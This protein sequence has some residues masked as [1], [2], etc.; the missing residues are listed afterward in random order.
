M[1]EK[2]VIER[3]KENGWPW[4]CVIGGRTV[5]GITP[6]DILEDLYCHLEKFCRIYK[7]NNSILAH[8]P[9]GAWSGQV[10]SDISISIRAGDI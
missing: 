9:F 6:T 2:I 8:L 1:T 5:Y 7:A 3:T 10:R 4:K